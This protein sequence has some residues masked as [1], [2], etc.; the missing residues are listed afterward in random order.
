MPLRPTTCIPIPNATGSFYTVNLA[1]AGA[2]QSE[3]LRFP[4][5]ND[6]KDLLTFPP[7]VP[8]FYLD[9]R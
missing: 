4:M 1:T 5:L 8:Y 9:D 3:Q 6:G 2:G 7:F